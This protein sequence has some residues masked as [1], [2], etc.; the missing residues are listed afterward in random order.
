MPIS[1]GLPNVRGK[2]HNSTIVSQLMKKKAGWL[3][4]CKTKRLRFSLIFS[5]KNWKYDGKDLFT[6]LLFLA[7]S[8]LH[9]KKYRVSIITH[10]Y[11]KNLPFCLS[12]TN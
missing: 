8:Q 6:I 1:A 3:F 4:S 11:I 7:S 12:R 5:A 9:K 10:I 2:S